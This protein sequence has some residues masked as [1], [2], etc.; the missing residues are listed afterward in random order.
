MEEE[1]GG[2]EMWEKKGEY[3]K[4]GVGRVREKEGRKKEEKE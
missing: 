4:E 1:R 3:E 2:G